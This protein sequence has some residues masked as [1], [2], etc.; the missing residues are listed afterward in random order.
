MKKINYLKQ[1]K[2]NAVALISL[3]IAI[4]SL[5]YSTWR[6][7]KTEDNRNQRYASFEILIKLNELQQVIFHHFYDKDIQ[8]KGNLRTGWTHVLTIDD[9]S[10]L[11]DDT[12]QKD[13]QKLHTIWENQW[14]DLTNSQ[15]SV[16][17]VLAAIDAVR[18]DS[19][20]RL[21]SLE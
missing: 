16:D 13:S 6:N 19:L 10:K 4:S 3:T 5:G 7:E 17:A 9:L 1:I 8:N 2:Q 12:I 21:K 20:N 14:Q 15:A 11:L 18:N